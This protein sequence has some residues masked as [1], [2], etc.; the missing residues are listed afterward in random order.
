MYRAD[1][2]AAMR[3]VGETEFVN[4]VAAM[5]ASG[6][7]GTVRACAGIVGHADLTLG[8]G[9]ERGAGGAYR[10]RRRPL[11]RHPPQLLRTTPIRTCSVRSA[12]RPAGALP[13]TRF[14]EGFAR[15]APLGMSFDAW[16]LEPQLPDL[17]DLARAF[18]DT[19]IV[20]DH[21]G[22]PLGIASYEGRR[23]ERFRRLARQHPRPGRNR[24]TSSSSW[25][26]WRWRF[27][28]S[29]RSWPSRRPLRRSWRTSGG[30]TSR[31][32]S[33]PSAPSAA[34][35]RAT[36]RST[37]AAATTTCCGTRSSVIAAGYSA[38]EKAALFSGTARRVYRLT[39]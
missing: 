27:P 26:A 11:P 24:R 37:S 13:S 10:G 36:S 29:P 34:C 8:D 4:G 25:A 9:V 22:T 16:L 35:S 39:V 30:P 31:P 32:A 21:V 23:E 18:P 33:R 3:P 5:C 19:P 17:I 15:L 7:Y 1:G 6:I 20:L 14:R 38:D 28:A 12:A 2:P